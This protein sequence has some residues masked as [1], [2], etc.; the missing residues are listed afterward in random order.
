[1]HGTK[2]FGRSTTHVARDYAPPASRPFLLARCF[3]RSVG[4]APPQ[5]QCTSTAQ[6]GIG[7]PTLQ[8]Q[9]VTPRG[10]TSTTPSSSSRPTVQSRERF[11]PEKW[12]RAVQIDPEIPPDVPSRAIHSSA[13]DTRIRYIVQ[14]WEGDLFVSPNGDRA[15]L[16]SDCHGLRN[17]ARA[18]RKPMCQYCLNDWRNHPDNTRDR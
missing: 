2:Q 1:M 9:A 16:R 5:A 17:A 3:V 14:P 10:R 8:R 7:S 15:H 13:V 6:D 12:S 11:Q 4:T 18:V